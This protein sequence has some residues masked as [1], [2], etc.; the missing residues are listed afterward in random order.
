MNPRQKILSVLKQIKANSE[1][2]ANENQVRF[3]FNNHVIGA[4]ILTNDEEARILNKLQVWGYVTLLLPNTEVEGMVTSVTNEDLMVN[5]THVTMTL[6]PNFYFRYHIYKLFTFEKLSWNYVNPVWLLF[7][8]FK[9]IYMAIRL[10]WSKGKVLTALFS[11]LGALL[12]YDWST[13]WGTTQYLIE[14][15]R[16]ILN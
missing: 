1:L 10:L 8:I 3:D 16:E 6:S 5:T 7:Q 4:G 15:F 12:I 13:A 9:H 14:I 11:S 2:N